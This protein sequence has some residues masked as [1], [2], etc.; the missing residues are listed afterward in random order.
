[1]ACDLEFTFRS[2][3]SLLEH[4]EILGGR[5]IRISVPMLGSTTFNKFGQSR[6][7]RSKPK[8]LEFES[9]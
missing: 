6:I 8:H 9:P 2:V 5:Q 3:L 7:P 1:M 4:V